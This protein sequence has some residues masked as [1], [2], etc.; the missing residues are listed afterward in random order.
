MVPSPPQPAG[1][2]TAANAPLFTALWAVYFLVHE[3]KQAPWSPRIGAALV[4]V[5]I[6]L[7]AAALWTLHDPRDARRFMVLLAL[8]IASVCIE[9]P[10]MSNCWLFTGLLGVALL[11]AHVRVLVKE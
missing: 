7:V 4:V 5:R 10:G 8:Q 9:L 11:G 2:P 3:V 1:H 6:L